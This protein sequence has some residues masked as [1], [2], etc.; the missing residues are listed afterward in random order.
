MPYI[1]SVYKVL[2]DVSLFSAG[3][4]LVVESHNYM[5]HIYDD[6]IFFSGI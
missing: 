1:V 3:E 6:N 5:Y 4:I 2:A